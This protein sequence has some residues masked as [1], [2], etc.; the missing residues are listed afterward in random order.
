MLTSL[1]RYWLM[2]SE[3][4]VFSFADLKMQGKTRWDGVRNYLA[5]N[6][7]MKEM[8]VGDII[9]FYHSNANPSGLAGLAKVSSLA[10]PDESAFDKKSE[11]F[12]EKSTRTKPRWYCVE[13]EYYQPIPR[14]VSLDEI[15]NTVALKKMVLL[16]NSRLSVQPVTEN[17]FLYLMELLKA[18]DR[19]LAH[20]LRG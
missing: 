16:N 1:P 12:D 3:P 17:E 15:R 14:F 18:P 10:A 2:K 20:E 8:T 9:L 7:M 13:V 4:D 11:Y 19:K 5:R 6:Y